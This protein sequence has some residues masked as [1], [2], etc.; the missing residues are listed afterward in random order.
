MTTIGY[1]ALQQGVGSRDSESSG[2]GGGGG[3]GG[4]V[5]GGGGGGGEVE[6]VEGG[7]EPAE[8]LAALGL[9]HDAGDGAAGWGGAAEARC[10]EYDD[11][12][13]MYER[14]GPLGP[15]KGW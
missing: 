12:F 15:D 4:D 7:Q 10:A 11:D 9:T 2:G 8:M 1:L 14:V 5:G 3:G 6:V 13:A